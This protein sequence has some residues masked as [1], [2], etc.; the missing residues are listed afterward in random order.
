MDHQEKKVKW[1][2]LVLLVILEDLEIR[3]IKVA[4]ERSDHRVKKVIGGILER[5][6]KGAKQ[7]HED[8]GDLEERGDLKAPQVLKV[9]QDNPVHLVFK[10]TKAH[11]VL[12]AREGLLDYQVLRGLTAKTV[13]PVQLVKEDL[14][15]SQD[16]KEQQ[17]RPE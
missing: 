7:G 2:F 9:I 16:H 15:V 12:K 8:F 17:E 6:E 14:Q 10:E 5:R 1:V 11:K 13:F 3:V 4:M